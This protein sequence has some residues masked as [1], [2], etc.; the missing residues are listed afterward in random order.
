[1]CLYQK[2][3]K[4]SRIRIVIDPR[5]ET[6]HPDVAC[7]RNLK[8]L[9]TSARVR[10]YLPNS[11]PV[12]VLRNLR[13]RPDLVVGIPVVLA[14]FRLTFVMPRA[15]FKEGLRRLMSF[16]KPPQLLL[17]NVELNALATDRIILVPAGKGFKTVMRE[18]S[19]IPAPKGRDWLFS[20]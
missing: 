4:I 5:T 11:P 10:S 9:L 19:L 12:I 20:V 8:G 1:M 7:F 15:V 13:F 18:N 16:I 3:D 6:R 17:T 2:R 14:M